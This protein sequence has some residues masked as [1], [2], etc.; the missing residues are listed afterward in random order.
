[1]Y[2]DVMAERESYLVYRN[3]ILLLSEAGKKD[4]ATQEL[5][6]HLLPMYERY[7]SKGQKLVD[8]AVQDGVERTDAIRLIAIGAQIFAVFASIAIFIFGFVLGYT[9]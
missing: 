4:Q 5:T 1:M 3:K 8:L 6:D 7:L 9:R 2:L